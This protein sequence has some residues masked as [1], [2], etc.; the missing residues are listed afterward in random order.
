MEARAEMSIELASLNVV[1]D[2]DAIYVNP[3]A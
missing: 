2:V 3:L 1:L